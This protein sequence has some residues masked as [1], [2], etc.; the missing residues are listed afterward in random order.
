MIASDH[1]IIKDYDLINRNH[2]RDI[3]RSRIEL[4]DKP[5]APKRLIACLAMGHT[6]KHSFYTSSHFQMFRYV[7]LILGHQ[8]LLT[9]HA[10]VA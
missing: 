4:A 2:D 6:L 7:C 10:E 9:E 5:T 1:T 8:I 3:R